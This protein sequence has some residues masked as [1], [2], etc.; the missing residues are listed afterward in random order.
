MVIPAFENMHFVSFVFFSIFLRIWGQLKTYRW[1]DRLD[2]QVIISTVSIVCVF[3]VQCLDAII[4]RH[5]L[6][7]HIH[8]D[9]SLSCLC[10]V[11]V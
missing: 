3:I 6:S 5:G 2:A 11:E 7:D 9:S 10:E 8:G 4:C 1:T